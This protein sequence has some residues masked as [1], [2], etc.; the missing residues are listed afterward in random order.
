[1]ARQR[2]DHGVNNLNNETNEARP[3]GAHEHTHIYLLLDRSGSMA[4]MVHDVIGGYNRFLADQQRDGAD[5]RITVVQFDSQHPQEVVM[6]GAPIGEARPLDAATYCPR[7]GTPLLD[8]TGLLISRAH[9][10][11]AARAVSGLPKEAIVFVTITDGE[12]NQSREYTLA[13]V[14]ERIAA[15]EAEGWTFVYLSAALSAYADAGGLGVG[16]G[17]TQA[18]AADATGADRAFADLSLKMSSFRDKKRRLLQAE[19]DPFWGHDKVAEADLQ[20]RRR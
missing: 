17:A 2:H 4:S 12:E 1:M 19:R 18:F 8:A 15:C 9:A 13:R 14:R 3:Q 10:E 20:R 5:A 6:A 16:V 11:A 7:G